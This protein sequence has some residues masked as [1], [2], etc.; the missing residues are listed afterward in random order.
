MLIGKQIRIR[1][2]REIG[3][4]RLLNGLT[5]IV[6]GR[7]PVVTGWYRIQLDE[8]SIT[9]HRSWTAPVDR[10]VVVEQSVDTN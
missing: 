4:A 6:V 8:N 5:G 3:S 10:L 7:H 9:P 1:A 2:L